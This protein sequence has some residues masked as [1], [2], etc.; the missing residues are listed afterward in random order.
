MS[1]C[2]STPTCG[3]LESLHTF[4]KLSKSI[5]NFNFCKILLSSQLSDF[6]SVLQNG[7]HFSYFP[8]CLEPLHSWAR[9]S[10][11]PTPTS[12]HATTSSTRS[13]FHKPRSWP[14]ISF[15]N[16]LFENNAEE[17]VWTNACSIPGFNPRVTK[18]TQSARIRKLT[19]TTS[20]TSTPGEDGSI[21]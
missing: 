21:P 5:F 1:H 9:L 14:K 12:W 10:K 6:K 18:T 13:S 8:V 17:Q 7:A 16:Y 19:L 4:C 20:K 11:R 2:R 15:A 3:A